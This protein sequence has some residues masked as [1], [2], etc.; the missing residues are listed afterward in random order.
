MVKGMKHEVEATFGWCRKSREEVKEGFVQATSQSDAHCRAIWFN[1]KNQFLHNNNEKLLQELLHFRNLL[2]TREMGA[3]SV[4]HQPGGEVM[5]TFL[6]IAM[7]NEKKTSSIFLRFLKRRKLGVDVKRRRL[8]ERFHATS[9]GR[10][11]K[12]ERSTRRRCWQG[13]IKKFFSRSVLF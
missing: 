2:T 9:V 6:L 8:L 7:V 12:D 3:W 1:K 10:W 5:F 13:F 11:R 4:Q